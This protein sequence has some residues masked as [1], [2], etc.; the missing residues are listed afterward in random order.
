VG[1][2]LPYQNLPF[3]QKPIGSSS[4]NDIDHLA[5]LS[6]LRFAH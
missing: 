4:A 6:Q 1:S 3:W 2:T 5:T